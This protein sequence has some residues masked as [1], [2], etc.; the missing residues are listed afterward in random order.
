MIDYVERVGFDYK[1]WKPSDI[2]SQPDSVVKAL[3]G[4]E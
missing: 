2:F 3:Q 4:A 1:P